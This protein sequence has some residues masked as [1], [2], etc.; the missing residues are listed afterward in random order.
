M[1]HLLVLRVIYAVPGFVMSGRTESVN[2]RKSV[3]LRTQII[4]QPQFLSL[5]DIQF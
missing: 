5:P 3:G 1:N 4:E 2:I